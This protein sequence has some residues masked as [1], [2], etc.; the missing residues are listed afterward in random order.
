[1]NQILG[2]VL[3]VF[4]G[5]FAVIFMAIFSQKNYDR[6]FAHGVQYEEH[7]VYKVRLLRQTRR[8]AR[9]EEVTD[10]T[11]S[12]E[13]RDGPLPGSD[14]SSDSEP[15]RSESSLFEHDA[16]AGSDSSAERVGGQGV[17]EVG[18]SSDPA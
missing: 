7:V 17:S 10:A 18:G 11:F 1:M 13:G 4:I 6:G 16:D 8:A 14:L 12:P 2:Y 3:I 5:L 9:A 15:E